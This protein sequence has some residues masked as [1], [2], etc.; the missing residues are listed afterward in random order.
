ML[1]RRSEKL[2]LKI[3]DTL[4]QITDATVRHTEVWNPKTTVFHRWNIYKHT[5]TWVAVK[6][7]LEIYKEWKNNWHHIELK[8]VGV[9]W[10]QTQTVIMPLSFICKQD[11]RKDYLQKIFRKTVR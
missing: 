5:N 7:P 2:Q 9:I 6:N 1:R 11:R 8:H 10:M 4:D 3:Q